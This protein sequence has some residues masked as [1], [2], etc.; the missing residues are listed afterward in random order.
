MNFEM[1][2]FRVK[3]SH[4]KWRGCGSGRKLSSESQYILCVCNYGGVVFYVLSCRSLSWLRTCVFNWTTSAS[5]YRRYVRNGTSKLHVLMDTQ[6]PNPRQCVKR[7][8][9]QQRV[10]IVLNSCIT[11]SNASRTLGI[12]LNFV[13][14]LEVGDLGAVVD[15]ISVVFYRTWW[16][17]LPRWIF[18][19]CW[20]RQRRQ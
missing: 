9:Y 11:G 17:S 3:G 19:S 20:K 14:S 7:D 13:V 2:D 15:L 16:S 1:V 18:T 8:W 5:S 6:V 4:V 10:H 12:S